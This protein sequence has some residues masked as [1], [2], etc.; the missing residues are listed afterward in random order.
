LEDLT[1]LIDITE[2]IAADNRF[3]DKIEVE[4][5]AIYIMNRG[6]QDF[7]RFNNINRKKAYFVTRLKKNIR[8]RRLYSS[9]IDKSAGLIFDQVGFLDGKLAKKR[10][11]GKV[12]AIK[13]NDPEHEVMYLFLTNSLELDALTVCKLYKQRW[14]ILSG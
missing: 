7:G 1:T 6:Y 8:F 5:N 10:Y 3:I 14:Q 12:R 11:S 4:K 2:A 13:Y 9:K